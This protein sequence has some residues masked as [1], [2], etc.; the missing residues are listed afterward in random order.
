MQEEKG[1][2]ASTLVTWGS[3]G[4]SRG[5]IFEDVND[6]VQINVDLSTI[7]EILEFQSRGHREDCLGLVGVKERSFRLI[8]RRTATWFEETALLKIQR[9]RAPGPPVQ[10][11]V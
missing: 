5:R 10:L 8:P 3:P 11:P 1:S 9:Q 6:I 7:D 2:C 4:F